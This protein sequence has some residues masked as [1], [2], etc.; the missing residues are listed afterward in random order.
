MDIPWRPMISEKTKNKTISKFR[1]TQN[2]WISRADWLAFLR[3]VA[4]WAALFKA[5]LI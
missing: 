5:V 4:E 3:M 1:Y 2:S